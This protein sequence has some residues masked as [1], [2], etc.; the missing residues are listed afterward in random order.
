MLHA[1][2]IPSSLT[3]KLWCSLL[4]I[5]RNLNNEIQWIEMARPWTK[6]NFSA[7]K[8]VFWVLFHKNCNLLFIQGNCV[9]VLRSDSVCRSGECRVRSHTLRRMEMGSTYGG[10]FHSI[11]RERYPRA[12]SIRISLPQQRRKAFVRCP[13]RPILV[14]KTYPKVASSSTSDLESLRYFQDIWNE[15]SA[16]AYYSQ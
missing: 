10:T 15:I 4:H 9:C 6:H 12:W 7:Y 14:Q 2:P 3:Y 13:K 8:N 16:F 1:L 5:K 11:R